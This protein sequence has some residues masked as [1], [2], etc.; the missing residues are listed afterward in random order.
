M[1]VFHDKVCCC[2]PYVIPARVHKARAT[3]VSCPPHFD[4]L[5]KQYGKGIVIGAALRRSTH[6]VHSLPESHNQTLDR[7]PPC[8]PT[9]NVRCDVPI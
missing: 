3:R 4:L 1:F 6:I 2:P 9:K 5:T 7:A 8:A